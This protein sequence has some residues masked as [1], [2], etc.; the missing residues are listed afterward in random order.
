[1]SCSE[2]PHCLKLGVSK[3]G[4]AL[5]TDLSGLLVYERPTDPSG[6]TPKKTTRGRAREYTQAFELAWKAYGRKDQKFEAFGVWIIR[7]KESGGEPALLTLVLGAL[8]WQG[9]A[10]A[11]EGWRFAPYFER[12]LKRRK[13]EDEPMPTGAGVPEKVA[14]SRSAMATWLD[15]RKAAGK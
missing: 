14:Q 12:Y 13:W 11:N 2:C 10:W 6:E 15:E 7:S 1:M 3:G 5:P 4:L 9:P 8:K